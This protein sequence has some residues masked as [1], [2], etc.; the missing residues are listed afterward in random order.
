MLN[1]LF[2]SIIDQDKM[3]IVVCNTESVIVYKRKDVEL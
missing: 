1:K 2:K 3:P